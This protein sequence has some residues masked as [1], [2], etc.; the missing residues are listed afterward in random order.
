MASFWVDKLIAPSCVI[1]IIRISPVRKIDSIKKFSCANSFKKML[2][3]WDIKTNR[4]H[5]WMVWSFGAQR[6]NN[7]ECFTFLEGN[8]LRFHPKFWCPNEYQLL[9]LIPWY[10]VDTLLSFDILFWVFRLK[11]YQS[12]LEPNVTTM[13]V[14]LA[15]FQENGNSI[16]GLS[17]EIAS[18]WLNRFAE[19][20]W[21]LIGAGI[22]LVRKIF[23]GNKYF[24]PHRYQISSGRC[25]NKD[26]PKSMR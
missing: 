9:S 19:S 2:D 23:F 15:I 17:A 26:G 13:H 6:K 21:I 11:V 8:V 7:E 4:C 22:S 20:F 25:R 10:H 1:K 16:I 24:L 18:T 5:V 12:V 3:F 14:W